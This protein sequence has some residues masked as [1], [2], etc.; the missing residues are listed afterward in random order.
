MWRSKYIKYYQKSKIKHYFLA[1]FFLSSFFSLSQNQLICLDSL[2]KRPIYEVRV[3]DLKNELLLQSDLF[4]K[5]YFGDSIKNQNCILKHTEYKQKKTKLTN[6]TIYLKVNYILYDEVEVKPKN[7]KNLF[8]KT[9]IN[10]KNK[11]PKTDFYG[12]I[13]CKNL[14]YI[15]LRDT[16][17]N[18]YDTN[19]LTLNY[20]IDFQYL[21]KKKK[22]QLIINAIDVEKTQYSVNLKKR[23]KSLFL[24]NLDSYF[25]RDLMDDDYFKQFSK[26]KKFE[27][28]PS[29]F[30]NNTFKLL[31]ENE[32]ETTELEIYFDEQDTTFQQIKSLRKNITNNAIAWFIED[33]FSYDS[34]NG[35]YFLKEY[36]STYINLKRGTINEFILEDIH[37]GVN[38]NIVDLGFRFFEDMSKINYNYFKFENNSLPKEYYLLYR[39]E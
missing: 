27:L 37:L 12:K 13:L 35:I 23:E 1:Y 31:K 28:I 15:I 36:K 22:P 10:S 26:R 4:G 17:F 25:K 16:N 11:T 32:D 20:T 5:I 2:T 6:D 21:Y 3:Y 24:F 38:E 34:L 7:I 9:L 33:G 14:E 39:K 30:E 29:N 19:L 8:I 18:N